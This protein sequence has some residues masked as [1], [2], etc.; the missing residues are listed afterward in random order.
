METI[1]EVPN[2]QP[3]LLSEFEVNLVKANA[4]KR[5]LNFIV[6]LLVFYVVYIV[7]LLIIPVSTRLLLFTPI[8]DRLLTAVFYGL[9]MSLVEGASK[10]K[11]VGKLF[12]RTRTVQEDGSP[13]T[14]EM[15]FTRGFSRIVPFEVF[16][17]LGDP[18]FPWH[19]K[20]SHT[21]VINEEESR[22]I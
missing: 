19:D 8:L 11:S 14:F 7:I 6:D 17:A 15:A 22:G 3:D 10:G 20:W 12:T 18:P 9:F 13:I 16:S 2:A 1:H 5:L 21:V 4:V